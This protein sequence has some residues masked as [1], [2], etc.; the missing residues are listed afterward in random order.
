MEG[1]TLINELN[2]CA[3][4]LDKAIDELSTYGTDRS[5]A[6]YE[7]KTALRK[8]ALDLKAEGMAVTLI[9]LTVYGEDEVAKK[10][11][12]R[13]IAESKHKTAQEKVNVLKLK[14]KLLDAQLTR[15]W[16]K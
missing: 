1:Y 8:H 4:D 9:Q 7:Y 13:D 5:C 3:A 12:D 15:E 16:G 6:E 11:L 2:A 10:R 14:C